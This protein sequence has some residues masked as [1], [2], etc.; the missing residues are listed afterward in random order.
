MLKM[1]INDYVRRL[2]TGLITTHKNLVNSLAQEC[3]SDI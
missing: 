3:G 2:L 1:D